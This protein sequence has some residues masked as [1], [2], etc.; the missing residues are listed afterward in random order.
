MA[1]LLRDAALLDERLVLPLVRG[2]AAFDEIV[3]TFVTGR[4]AHARG[5]CMQGLCT[6]IAAICVELN[7]A[8]QPT[9]GFSSVVDVQHF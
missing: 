7:A 1:V 3:C 2:A 5:C 9:G 8:L 6:R 4:W